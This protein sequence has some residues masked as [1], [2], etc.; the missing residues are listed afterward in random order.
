MTPHY[1]AQSSDGRKKRALKLGAA[2]TLAVTLLTSAIAPAAPAR[3]SAADSTVKIMPLG[4]SITYGMADEGGYRKYLSYLLNQNGYSN[5]DLVGPEGKDSAS[6]NY[7]GQNITYD[8]NHAGYSGYTIVNMQGG[9]FGQLNGILETMQSGD[10]ITKYSP[11][12]ILLQIGTND[13]NNGHVTDS[14]DHLR[15]LLDYLREKMPSN[16]KIFLTTIP[17]LGNSGWGGNSDKNGD[18]AAYNEIVKKVAGEY[19]SKNVIFADIHSVIDGTKDL[20]D[21]VHPNAGGYE[22]MGKYWFD[23]IKPYLNGQNA[24]SPEDPATQSDTPPSADNIIGDANGDGVIDSL[25]LIRLRKLAVS[26][27]PDA[28]VLKRCDF[29][30]DK[31]IGRND[32]KYVSDFISGKSDTLPEIVQSGPS[33]PQQDYPKSYDFPAVSQLKSSKDVP[34]PFIFMDGSKVETPDDWWKRQAEISCLYE[35]YMYGKWIDG[36]DDEVTYSISGNKMTVNIK[37]KS[38]GKSASFPVN[39]NLPDKVRHDGGAP[40]IVGMHSGIAE[41]TATANGYAV[42]TI[43]GDV[44][45]NPVAADSTAHTGPFY[46]LYPYGNNWDEQTGVLMAWS[47]GCSKI[48]DALYNGAANELNINPDNSIVTGVSR[49]GKATAVCGAFDKRFKMC[50]PSCSGAGGIALYRYMS[51]G[52]SYDFSSKGASSSYRYGQNEPLGSLQSSGERGWFNNRFMEFNDP[53]KFPMDQHM[54]GSL[55]CDPDRYLFIIGSCVSEDWVN[56]PSMWMSYCGMKKIWDYVGLSDNL[57]INIHKEGHAVIAEDVEKMIQYF[58]YHVYG[59]QPTMDLKQ[60]QTS[61]FELPKNKDSYQ[62]TFTSKWIH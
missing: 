33:G 26:G 36:S 14:E 8:D 22:K 28:D 62:D 48:L 11:D 49:W 61:V 45:S 40:V 52:K 56:A 21:G 6:F 55:C 24:T 18:I 12:I 3:T 60:L 4:D 30:G 27:N 38:T 19:S 10:Y 23:T 15:T 31:A 7:N 2:L 13:V 9:W 16:G 25:D 54:L 35:Y 46:T 34:D 1:S 57:A 5:V 32:I 17:D 42:L 44:F 47:W 58:D 50:A 51:E 43:G 53:N 37:R 29:D 39:I 59:I 41:S 20:A